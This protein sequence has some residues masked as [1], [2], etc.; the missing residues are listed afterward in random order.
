ML[1]V[2]AW[3]VH[4][5]GPAL[6][7]ASRSVFNVL[8]IVDR[9]TRRRRRLSAQ[10]LFVGLLIE[11]HNQS[12]PLPQGRGPEIAGRAEQELEE[13]RLRRAGLAQIHVEDPLSFGHVEVVHVG[14]Y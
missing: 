5:G 11:T 12:P 13:L 9:P 14:E 3:F 1:R 2:R 6:S 4:T 7:P 8:N 10:H